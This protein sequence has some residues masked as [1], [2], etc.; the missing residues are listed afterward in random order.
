MCWPL[1]WL[2]LFTSAGQLFRSLSQLFLAIADRIFSKDL[3]TGSH[4]VLVD[5]MICQV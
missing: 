5:A 2:E 4:L 1:N 3:L